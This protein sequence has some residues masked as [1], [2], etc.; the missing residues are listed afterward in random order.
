MYVRPRLTQRKKNF[1]CCLLRLV[2]KVSCFLD[3]FFF[4]FFS[5]FDRIYIPFLLEK[6]Y[7]ECNDVDGHS[8]TRSRRPRHERKNISNGLLILTS[9]LPS[10]YRNKEKVKQ[11]ALSYSNIHPNTNK[12][13]QILR[14]LHMIF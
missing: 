10:F 1:F 11:K 3:L 14:T 5:A 4:D 8:I 7:K 12:S 6:S 13:T 9:S 2:W